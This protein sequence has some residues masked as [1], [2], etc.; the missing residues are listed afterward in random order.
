M[1]DVPDIP[2][3][4]EIKP[5][6]VRR[7]LG[8]VQLLAL[9]LDRSLTAADSKRHVLK[10]DVLATIHKGKG[11]L[12]AGEISVSRTKPS[13]NTTLLPEKNRNKYYMSFGFGGEE[14]FTLSREIEETRHTGLFLTV[15][16]VTYQMTGVHT[17]NPEVPSQSFMFKRPDSVGPEAHLK[18]E[19]L[20]E[21][22]GPQIRRGIQ[23]L[24]SVPGN[25]NVDLGDFDQ[26]ADN[27]HTHLLEN[28]ELVNG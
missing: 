21:N 20:A 3:V 5:E 10:R 11:K 25:E 28:G 16:G 12:V 15:D 22:H 14:G 23:V 13:H 19:E 17:G 2:K 1:E 18:T 27:V 7:F 6:S 4:E 8:Q 24:K 9:K 26:L